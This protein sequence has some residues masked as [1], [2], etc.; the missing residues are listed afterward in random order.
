[1]HRNRRLGIVQFW[2]KRRP[3]IRSFF[4]KRHWREHYQ[5]SIGAQKAS[6]PGQTCQNPCAFKRMMPEVWTK[7]KTLGIFNIPKMGCQGNVCDF[8]FKAQ[9]PRV[10][11]RN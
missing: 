7:E 2:A 11:I 5:S 3:E 1:M 6:S 10:S 9:T 8:I 4:V